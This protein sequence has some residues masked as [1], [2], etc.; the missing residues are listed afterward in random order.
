MA[1]GD[2]AVKIAAM[3]VQFGAAETDWYGT[4]GGLQSAAYAIWAEDWSAAGSYLLTAASTF[5]NGMRHICTSSSSTHGVRYHMKD[6]LEL[7]D[8]Q[9]PEESGSV[10]MDSILTAMT[11]ASFEQLTS[12]MGITQA[13]KTAVWDAPFNEEYYAALARGF[14]TWGA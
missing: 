14:K 5:R 8:D 9:W 11:T 3:D 4:V 7:I 13:Y 1:L 12:F 10:D 2:L 6:V